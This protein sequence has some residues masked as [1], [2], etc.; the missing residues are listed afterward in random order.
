MARNRELGITARP[1]YVSSAADRRV[2]TA[3]SATSTRQAD[4]AAVAKWRDRII[5]NT[6]APVVELTNDATWGSPCAR[7]RARTLR[8]GMA[9]GGRL[10]HRDV[11][12]TN[13]PR[14]AARYVRRG[15]ERIGIVPTENVSYQLHPSTLGYR[16]SA[17]FPGR[18]LCLE[19]SRSLLADPFTPFQEMKISR[20]KAARMAAPIAAGYLGASGGL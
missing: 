16:F 3:V 14:R 6:Y 11:E 13:S 8:R 19:L 4:Y 5:L 2:L 9:G 10:P 7:L 18:V 12:G 15:Y 20:D 17:R 1:E